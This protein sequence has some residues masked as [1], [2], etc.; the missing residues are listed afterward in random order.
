MINALDA[1]KVAVHIRQSRCGCVYAF[2]AAE[3]AAARA[4][5]Q[6]S[7]ES[8]C[9]VM[10]ETLEEFELVDGRLKSWAAMDEEISPLC[11]GG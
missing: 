6:T 7:T 8:Q 3:E 9:D 11:Y 1:A 10:I 4:S 5:S 2:G